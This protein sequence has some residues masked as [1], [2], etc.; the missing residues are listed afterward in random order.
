MVFILK[1]IFS[2]N[3]FDKYPIRINNTK[4]IPWTPFKFKYPVMIHDGVKTCDDKYY[5]FPLS[6]T[7]LGKVDEYINKK[8]GLPFDSKLRK[9][10]RNANKRSPHNDTA[11]SLG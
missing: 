5:I 6:S 9:G 10:H 4:S 2:Y 7:G 1:S 11:S 3:F 8:R